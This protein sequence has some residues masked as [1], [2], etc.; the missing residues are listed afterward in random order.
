MKATLSLLL[1]LV[2]TT[3]VAQES[4]FN[5]GFFLGATQRLNRIEPKVDEYSSLK[6][7]NHLGF[8]AGATFYYQATGSIRA[9]ASLAAR[10]VR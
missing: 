9:R 5:Y 6:A 4:K 10:R 1:M 8:G 2:C 3:A 7:P